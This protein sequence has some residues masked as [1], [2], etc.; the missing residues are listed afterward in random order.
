[1]W[2]QRRTAFDSVIG[3]APVELVADTLKTYTPP[4]NLSGFVQLL[5]SPEGN[6][7]TNV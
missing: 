1:M 5:V 7:W 4:G 3:L 2:C 6:E